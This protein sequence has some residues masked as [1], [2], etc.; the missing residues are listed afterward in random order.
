MQLTTSQLIICIFGIFLPNYGIFLLL[1]GYIIH[2]NTTSAK[3]FGMLRNKPSGNNNHV[4]DILQKYDYCVLLDVNQNMLPS[5]V[6]ANNINIISS[7]AI[8]D[9]AKL[10]DE[11][12]VLLRFNIQI[13]K[14]IYIDYNTN[15]IL[16]IYKQLDANNPAKYAL[17]C[18]SDNSNITIRDLLDYE[19]LVSKVQNIYN[20]LGKEFSPEL[21]QKWTREDIENMMILKTLYN[22]IF[23]DCDD[24]LITAKLNGKTILFE[25]NREKSISNILLTDVDTIDIITLQK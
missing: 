24:M 13:H 1:L 9:P 14:H 25:H 2:L 10:L 11:L 17:L 4:Q 22:N 12:S 8:I 5:G 6:Y 20:L 23:T 16:N 19:Q 15:L 21:I 3:Q 18:K 7:E